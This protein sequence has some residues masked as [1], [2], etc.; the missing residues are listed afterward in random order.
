MF[1]EDLFGQV[2]EEKEVAGVTSKLFEARSMKSYDSYKILAQ[3][4]SRDSLMA[5]ITP[6]KE[7]RSGGL[8]I[9]CP[10]GDDLLVHVVIS[11]CFQRAFR[12][13]LQKQEF[14]VYDTE[15]P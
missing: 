9:F 7:V 2:A 3:V 8:H 13:C 12:N 5:F 6:L 14:K 4:I 15:I 11:G 1:H 10:N